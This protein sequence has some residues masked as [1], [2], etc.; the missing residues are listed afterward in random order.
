M[1]F[2]LKCILELLRVKQWVKN[3]FIFFPLL[4]AGQFFQQELLINTLITFF[5]F[6]LASSGLYILNDYLDREQDRFH[7]RKAQRPLAQGNF[8]PIV[9]KSLITIF[10]LLGLL[11][12]L[13][14][15]QRVFIAVL[16][17]IA[18]HLLYNTIMRKVVLLDVIFIAFGF[19]IRIGAGSLAANVSPSVWLLMCVFLLALFLGFTK[20]R[21]EISSLGEKASQHRSVL[22]HYN[23]YLLDQIIIICSTLAIV[24]YGLYTISE[25]IF[26]RLGSY[27]LAYSLVFVIYGIF[28]YLYLIHMHKKGDDPGEILAT[29]SPLLINVLLWILFVSYILY[30]KL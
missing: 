29:D 20:R 13:L 7:P 14:V 22:A 17:Y 28:R 4:F 27:H 24:F 12:C 30:T 10:I 9:I 6:C 15:G 3:T 16:I 19:L 25:D 11:T 2:N 5:G 21:Y 26:R 18:L 1:K 8:N 23:I